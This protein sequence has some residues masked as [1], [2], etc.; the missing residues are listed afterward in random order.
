MAI[1]QE[2]KHHADT[3]KKEPMTP[4]DIAFLCSLQTELNTQDNMGN[5]DPVFWVIKGS[6]FVASDDGQGTASLYICEDGTEYHRLDE[7]FHDLRTHGPISHLISSQGYLYRN[8]QLRTT[9]EADSENADIEQANLCLHLELTKNEGLDVV[10]YNLYTLQQ[11]MDMLADMDISDDAAQ[12][13]YAKEIPYI[14]PDT[15]FITHVDAQNHLRR[16]GYNYD[17]HAHA[18]AMTATRSERFNRLLHILRITDWTS[19]QNLTANQ[20]QQAIQA[21]LAEIDAMQAEPG[22]TDASLSV[23][24]AH[25]RAAIKA[26]QYRL[27]DLTERTDANA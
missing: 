3:I 12:L 22:E 10:E 1:F 18:Y 23:R 5:A 15:L 9:Y 21:E 24:K 17:A 14:Y 11:V 16:Y 26:F 2:N 25:W 4:E 6:K 19:L 20:L 7:I 27:N 13:V 8:L